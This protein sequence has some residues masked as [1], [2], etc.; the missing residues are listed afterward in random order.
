MTFKQVTYILRYIS[1]ILCIFYVH[2]LHGMTRAFGVTKLLRSLMIPPK[3][4]THSLLSHTLSSP[5]VLRNQDCHGFALL[6]KKKQQKR[7]FL[8]PLS[9]LKPSPSLYTNSLTQSFPLGHDSSQTI[10]ISVFHGSIK[11]RNRDGP[12]KGVSERERER[13]SGI[14]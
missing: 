8:Q 1:F 13:E 6:P 11:E 10:T 12:F 14:L 5:P 2:V 3:A 9:I 4:K 7:T